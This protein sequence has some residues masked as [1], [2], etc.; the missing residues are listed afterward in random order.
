EQMVRDAEQHAEED[1]RRREAAETRNNAET[2]V[3]STEKML[4]DYAD[5]VPADVKSE[6][7]S[8]VADLKEKLKGDDITAIRQATERVSTTAQRVGQ[9][10]YGQAPGAAASG[11]TA[12]QG[13]A[14]EEVVEAEVVDDDQQQ[15]GTG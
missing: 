12:H 6:V 9:A 3:Y 13:T 11:A 4:R 1:R 15:G 5:K 8:A 2:L 14:D 10:I 7:E